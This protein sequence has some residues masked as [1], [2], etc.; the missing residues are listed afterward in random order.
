MLKQRSRYDHATIV[1][2][3]SRKL[4]VMGNNKQIPGIVCK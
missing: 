2:E 4:G 3:Y 1:E